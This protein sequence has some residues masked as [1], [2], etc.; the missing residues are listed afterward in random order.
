MFRLWDDQL[1][2][3]VVVSGVELFVF[4]VYDDATRAAV[5]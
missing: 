1:E 3:D 4:V 5:G 2:C